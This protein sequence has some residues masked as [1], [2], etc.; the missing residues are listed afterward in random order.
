MAVNRYTTVDWSA[1][2]SSYIPKPFEQM[3]MVGKTMQ[4]EHADK[5]TEADALANEINK[6]K[7][8]NS[9]ISEG[10]GD[11][12][13]IKSRSTGYGEFKNE[14]LNKY[15]QA[16]KQL[17]DEYATTGDANKFNQGVAK[18]KSDFSGDYQKLKIAEAN[19]AAIEESDKKYRENKDAGIEGNSYIL[20]KLAEEGR[21]LITNPFSYSY[22]G[23]PI[24]EA[25]KLEEEVNKSSQNYAD[26]IGQSGVKRDPN[27]GYLIWS[28]TH[29]VTPERIKNEVY[30]TFDK[31]VG[32]HTSQ[33]VMRSLFDQGIKPDAE[34]I[35][36]VPIKFDNRGKPLEYKE[37]KTTEFNYRY[38]KTKEDFANAVVA[39]AAKSVLD[40]SEKKDWMFERDLDKQ[41]AQDIQTTNE[42]GNAE[43]VDVNTVLDSWGLSGVLDKEGNVTAPTITDS[44]YIVTKVDGTK[45]EFNSSVEAHKFA[46]STGSISQQRAS[47]GESADQIVRNAYNKMM[48]VFKSLGLKVLPGETVAKTMYDYAQKVAVQRST[49]TQLQQSTSKG[50]TDFFLGNNSNI[51]NMEVYEQGNQNSNAKLTNEV[52]SSLANNSKITGVDYFGNNQA[53]WKVAVTPKDNS[54]NITGQDQALIAIPKDL[55][56]A[57]ETKPVWKISKGALEFA[58]TGKQSP[59]YQDGDATPVIENVLKT[60]YGANAPKIVA[61][62][63]DRNK[64]GEIILRGSYVDN[65]NNQ[66]ELK[67]IEYNVAK[68]T[69]E[70]L[71]LGEIQ[72]RKTKE[73]ETQGSLTQYNT[74]LGETIKDSEVNP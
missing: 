23:A 63:T 62:S 15:T 50:M 42:Q 58:K 33:Q 24:G 54:G 38:N 65:S 64:K 37:I 67:A 48:P 14:V 44:K 26:Q 11:D 31:G 61:S 22:K 35:I 47:S 8:A 41:D 46:G 13:G 68:G 71:S 7:V 21:N 43:S 19:S 17:S 30:N 70:L 56:F 40:Q 10:S 49:T 53:G 52:M 1:P 2:T 66:A 69:F 28:K 20:N 32:L 34:K 5:Q 39:K 74:R 12:L 73:I 16:N 4:K 25:L 6:I 55:S 18:L 9:V 72:K 45:K 36:K 3:M 60:N 27:T 51:S 57:T 59:E 29:G